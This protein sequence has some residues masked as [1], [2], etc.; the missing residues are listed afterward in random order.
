M[1]LNKTVTSQGSLF[2]GSNLERAASL[3]LFSLL[4]GGRIKIRKESST[5]V[6]KTEQAPS[7]TKYVLTLDIT[8]DCSNIQLMEKSHV[9]KFVNTI[10]TG[11]SRMSQCRERFNIHHLN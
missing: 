2:P 3:P 6:K 4:A 11:S 8:A 5:Q 1:D 10:S 9:L 7:H